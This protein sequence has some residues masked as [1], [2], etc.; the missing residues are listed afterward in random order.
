MCEVLR[1]RVQALI[2]L[3]VLFAHYQFLWEEELETKTKPT[4]Y[5][6]YLV[7]Y[8]CFEEPG[9]SYAKDVGW[10]GGRES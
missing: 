4:F 9:N 7:V 1:V 5:P 3:T 2:A 6:L 8:K 10:E